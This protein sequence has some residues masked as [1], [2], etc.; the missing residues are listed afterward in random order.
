LLWGKNPAVLV[1]DF[2]KP[3]L[4]S[5]PGKLACLGLGFQFQLPQGRHARLFLFHPFP[6]VG[7][8]SF[9]LG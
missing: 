8:L 6:F 4:Q 5:D 1:G 2:L 9:V 3:L 7:G